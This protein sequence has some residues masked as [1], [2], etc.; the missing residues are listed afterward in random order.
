MQN[1]KP[2][3]TSSDTEFRGLVERLLACP[4][5]QSDSGIEHV[6][7]QLPDK[8]KNAIKY[9]PQATAKEKVTSLL[10]ACLNYPQGLLEL[11]QI[12]QF[13]DAGT[14]Q[15]IGLL[16]Y[17]AGILLDSDT[18]YLFEF[19]LRNLLERFDEI[20]DIEPQELTTKP[21]LRPEPNSFS[22]GQRHPARSKR[23]TRLHTLEPTYSPSLSETTPAATHFERKPDEKQTKVRVEDYLT[24]KR[25][26]VLLGAP[27]AGKST[28]LR[29]LFRLFLT[30][31][32]DV[33]WSVAN[34]KPNLG[35]LYGRVPLF[36]ELGRWHDK[37]QN[38]LSFL[39]NY[40][41]E[42]LEDG[43]K[44]SSLL[45]RE[46]EGQRELARLI[47]SMLPGLL[48]GGRLL[49]LLDGLNE[50]PQLERNDKGQVSDR[51]VESLA[52]LASPPYNSTACILTCR[53]GDFQVEGQVVSEWLD[54]H[55][56]PLE[57]AEVM[58][59]AQA[60]YEDKGQA[61]GLSAQ[62]LTALYPTNISYEDDS[63]KKFRSLVSQPFY[64]V[65]LL[66]YYH[67]YKTF[68][69]N[70]ARLLKFSV[71]EALEG[72]VERGMLPPEQKERLLKALS[73]LA[74]NMSDASQVGVD[75]ISLAIAWL[76][77]RRNK[78]SR[79]NQENYSEPEARPEEQVSAKDLLEWA[80]GSGILRGRERNGQKETLGV[81]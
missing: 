49:L 12:I 27:G 25:R 9:A 40:L 22:L 77:H 75:Q 79:A 10:Q 16:H 59:F 17:T 81:N 28:T 32:Q 51:R 48:E 62:L 42:E 29:R 45:T 78:Q 3:F 11:L 41:S 35:K 74:F 73:L 76:F 50:M 15:F 65:R 69:Q 58:A 46:K 68:P 63:P 37:Q 43:L 21:G 30:Y 34:S 67:E 5:L 24:Q 71:D 64:L 39:Q 55:V 2:C 66:D 72:A 61:G 52:R 47:V 70:P 54:L 6:T 53:V 80:V 60:Y 4:S 31:W 38:L 36:V 19:Y 23:L 56:L 26:M 14:F 20:D 44:N 8:L 13:Y 33:E 1:K 57:E 18:G 7:H